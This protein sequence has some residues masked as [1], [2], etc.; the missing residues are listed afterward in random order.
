MMGWLQKLGVGLREPCA[1]RVAGAGAAGSA[2]HL[3]CIST[4]ISYLQP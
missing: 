1:R 2:P 3:P 4:T